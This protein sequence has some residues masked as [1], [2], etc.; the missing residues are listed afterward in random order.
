MVGGIGGE[1]AEEEG[2][3][4]G[5]ATVGEAPGMIDA[6]KSSEF[7]P[8]VFPKEEGAVGGGP[9]AACSQASVVVLD[10]RNVGLPCGGTVAHDCGD[11][12]LVWGMICLKWQDAAPFSL[13]N[14]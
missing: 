11:N 7:R 1:A 14:S 3:F 5:F 8:F 12:A 2:G 9:T 6:H 4:G 10:L 13:R